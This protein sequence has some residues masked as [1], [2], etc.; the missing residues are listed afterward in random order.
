[1]R[2]IGVTGGVGAGKSTVLEYL[3]KAYHAEVIQADQVGHEVMEPG[4]AAYDE[5][6][7]VFGSEVRA[8]DGRIDRKILGDVVFAGEEMRRKLNAIVHPAVKQEILRRIAQA[9][10]EKKDCVVVEAALF[11]EEKYD[12]F[13]DETWYIF[14]EEKYDAF[15]DETWYIY[16][17]ENRRRSRLKASRWYTDER[18]DRIFGSQKT[19]EEFLK[20]CGCVI[21]NNGAQEDTCRQIDKRMKR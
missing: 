7:N 12:A 20:R 9:Q 3:E 19:H 18:I 15:C 2:V 10:A 16:T 8:E 11:L 13:C 5:I 6:L 17:A 4:Q 21:D 14:L 1:M